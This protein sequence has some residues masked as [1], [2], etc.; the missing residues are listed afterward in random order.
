MD[1][2]EFIYSLFNQY[3]F[4]DAKN[5]IEQIEYFVKTSPNLSNN[6]LAI[7]LVD[8]IKNFS[9]VTIDVPLFQS[10]LS[11][12]GKSPEESNKIM[13][14]IVKWKNFN[15]DQI[16]P[17]RNILKSVSTFYSKYIKEM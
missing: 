9:L 2:I 4:Q 3:L 8:S 10:M 13:G 12:S 5:N 14:D 7:E 16:Q 6:R 15:N 1:N 11:R 17:A